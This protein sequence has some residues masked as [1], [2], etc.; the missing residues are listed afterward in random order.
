[1]SSLKIATVRVK[2]QNTHDKNPLFFISCCI[3]VTIKL[4]EDN[5]RASE[6]NN[7]I[8]IVVSKNAVTATDVSL[9]I[10]PVTVS[11]AR[12]RGLFP[13]GAMPPED[14]QGHSPVIAGQ[15]S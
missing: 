12:E 7:S 3:V 11:E 5:Y 10:T 14:L 1:M 2:L 9:M 13:A 4:T 15:M 8:R 6:A